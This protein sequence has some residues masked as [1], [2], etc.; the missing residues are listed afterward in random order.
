MAFLFWPLQSLRTQQSSPSAALFK[1]LFCVCPL[2]S[3]SWFQYPPSLGKE[4]LGLIFCHLQ[5]EGGAHSPLAEVLCGAILDIPLLCSSLSLA[6]GWC[7]SKEGVKKRRGQSSR[8]PL[9]RRLCSKNTKGT[10]VEGLLFFVVENNH[11]DF[12]LLM[13]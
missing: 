1:A 5:R 3:I 2:R 12:L 11:L 10:E 6:C 8:G 13:H 9:S 4:F 7:F